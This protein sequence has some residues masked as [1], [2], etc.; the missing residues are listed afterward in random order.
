[1]RLEHRRVLTRLDGTARK[2]GTASSLGFIVTFLVACI[3]SAR[4]PV[5]PANSPAGMYAVIGMLLSFILLLMAFG[6]Q[7]ASWL[8]RPTEG[9]VEASD[10][11]LS[12]PRGREG[13]RRID[14][15]DIA[16]G[17][18]LRDGERTMTE[19]RLRDGN[20][21]E[22]E[23]RDEHEGA[24]LLDTLGV[25]PHERALEMRLGG[26]VFS[27]LT[28]LI[29]IGPGF[30]VAGI[31]SLGLGALLHLS[32]T[33][34]GFMIFALT[35]ASAPVSQWLWA[36]GRVI[37]GRDGISMQQGLNRWFVAHSDVRAVR[38]SRSKIVLEL[39]DRRTQVIG[40]LGMSEE[41]RDALAARIRES[42][43]SGAP[44]E[45]LSA[46]LALLDRGSKSHAEWEASLRALASD[47]DGYRASGLSREELLE[48]IDSATSSAERKVAAAF[49]LS[50]R[51]KAQAV[52]RVRVAL[53]V[54]AQ[55]SVRVALERA[56][57]GALDEEAIRQ[58]EAT[59][60]R[61]A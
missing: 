26:A 1:M 58:A 52:E 43:G 55:E 18:V 61:V 37:V 2:L 15:K 36:N 46:R 34:M 22:V 20:G 33:A 48:V 51:D 11:A 41:R 57:E 21:V 23:V 49:V 59:R 29:G 6:T 40:T 17:F 39:T 13:E 47:G 24:A 53:A 50:L 28:A 27:V 35:A 14:R 12:V 30:L 38:V 25:A 31:A 5:L 54:T 42:I 19:L 32:S 16:A 45:A 60:V 4:D 44:T 7:I 10:A 3:A 8:G 56:S 9:T